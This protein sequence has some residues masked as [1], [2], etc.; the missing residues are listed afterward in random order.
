MTDPGPSHTDPER[1]ADR[2]DALQQ[3]AL[4]AGTSLETAH[5]AMTQIADLC[6]V[7][8]PASPEADETEK[9]ATAATAAA[10]AEV[11]LEAAA[12]ELERIAAALRAT[13]GARSEEDESTGGENDGR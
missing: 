9:A 13:A 10:R 7:D 12:D 4:R 11:S 5:R 1:L 6:D 3:T 8:V 2:L